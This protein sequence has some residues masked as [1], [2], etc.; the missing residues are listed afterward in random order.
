MSHGS[1]CLGA[2]MATT[3]SDMRHGDL[4]VN[5]QSSAY[6]WASSQRVGAQIRG[7]VYTRCVWW[8]EA[9]SSRLTLQACIA[10]SETV[11]LQA[12]LRCPCA[13]VLSQRLTGRKCAM[14]SAARYA[15]G[16]C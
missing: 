2:G 15:S 4:Y 10:S 1:A 13:L 8:D 11:G 7:R 6:V 5:F 14:C 12:A 3:L 16:Q 9:C